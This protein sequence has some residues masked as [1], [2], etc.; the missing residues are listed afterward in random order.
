MQ[1]TEIL[2]IG[3][4]LA[5]AVARRRARDGTG[6]RRDVRP[7][8]KSSYEHGRSATRVCIDVSAEIH[9]RRNETGQCGFPTGATSSANG[10][11]FGSVKC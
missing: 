8:A 9:A 5:G 10:M 4:G 11:G 3:S 2:I 1:E 6:A 7:G